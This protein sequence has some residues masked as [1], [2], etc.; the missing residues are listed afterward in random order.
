M[1]TTG[2]SDAQIN[3]YIQNQLKSGKTGQQVYQQFKPALGD[4]TYQQAAQ[5]YNTYNAQPAPSQPVN[6]IPKPPAGGGGTNTIQPYTQPGQAP[7]TPGQVTTVP[8]QVG[9]PVTG[10]TTV[11]DAT[12]QQL[13]NMLA[14]DP[15]RISEHDPGLGGA[16]SA[17]DR[18]N[19]RGLDR[20]KSAIAEQMYAQGITGGGVDTAMQGAQ[21]QANEGRAGFVG[22][23]MYQELQNRRD[24]LQQALQLGAGLLTAEQE[25]K[26]KKQLGDLDAAVRRQGY[27]VQSQLG[28]RELDIRRML[29]LGD[30]ALGVRGQDLGNSQFL[31]NLGF[32]IG[33]KQADL[34]QNAIGALI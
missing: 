33:S 14:T 1:A 24:Q 13:L 27:T 20:Q 22:N 26:L 16:I 15:T 21:Q 23:L 10:T 4:M 9:A 28:N 31:Q 5:S 7:G 19:Q 29:G 30:L 3:T 18:Q 11:T 32:L 17:Y 12:R 2:Y 25:N 8:T 6:N 34:N